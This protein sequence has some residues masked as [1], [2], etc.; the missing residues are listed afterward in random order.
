MYAIRDNAGIIWGHGPT[1]E[2]ANDDAHYWLTDDPSKRLDHETQEDYDTA[3]W[4][5]IEMM[6]VLFCD[7]SASKQ[8]YTN[9]FTDDGL[10]YT[11]SDKSITF[12]VLGR[13]IP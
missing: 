12:T 10:W 9:G 6:D 7:E 4:E 3:V 5:E 8:L 11:Y 1:V 2:E 13:E